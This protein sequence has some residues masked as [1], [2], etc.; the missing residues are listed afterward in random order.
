MKHP[1]DE[2]PVYRSYDDNLP[3]LPLMLVIAGAVIAMFG[4]VVFWWV[5]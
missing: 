3:G 5:H 2:R 1:I 4:W